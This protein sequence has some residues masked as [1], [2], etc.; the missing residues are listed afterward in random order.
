MESMSSEQ[1]ISD[2]ND[3]IVLTP[4]NSCEEKITGQSII[5]INPAENKDSKS[6]T[7]R[8]FE[9]IFMGRMSRL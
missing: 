8:S 4:D 7:K 3:D 5:N 6:N 1:E 9:D 2:D